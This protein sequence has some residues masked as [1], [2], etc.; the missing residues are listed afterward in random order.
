MKQILFLGFAVVVLVAHWL[1]FV[2]T[3][4]IVEGAILL[5]LAYGVSQFKSD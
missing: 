5:L 4:P 1:V 2:S 3:P